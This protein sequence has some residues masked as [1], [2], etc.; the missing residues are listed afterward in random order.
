MGQSKVDV[1]AVGRGPI[2][3]NST[4]AIVI[5]TNNIIGL[6]SSA[7]TYSQ[8]N[9]V[10]Y[11]GRIYRSKIN[12]NTN[13]QPD[14]SPNQYE[15]LYNT[16]R[17]GD[18]A[19]VAMGPGSGLWQRNNSIWSPIT[20]SPF[21]V[22]LVDGQVAAATAITFIGNTKAFAQLEYTL[23]RGAG[24]GRKRKGL[25]N[26]LNDTATTVEYAHEFNE[27]GLDVNAFF[28][29]TI[30]AGNVNLQYTSGLEGV[31]LTLEF[32]LRGWS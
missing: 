6:W 16:P 15:V 17:D 23:A 21:T 31:A 7:T 22:N 26:V 10:E 32:T 29:W 5:S 20:P 2:S 3:D 14:I 13:N 1:L 11:S 30:S 25:F 18:I 9:V 4:A 19:I 27:I 8:Y 28:N 12:S 24:H